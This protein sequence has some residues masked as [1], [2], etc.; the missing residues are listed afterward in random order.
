MFVK[1]R[2]FMKFRQL[3]VAAAAGVA[4]MAAGAASAAT[5]TWTADDLEQTVSGGSSS[6]SDVLTFTIATGEVG[7]LSG[8]FS[9][10]VS[11]TIKAL[12]LT[13]VDLLLGSTVLYSS[14]SV[15]SFSFTGLT[16][17]SYSLSLLYDKA[18]KKGGLITGY[19]TLTTTPSV[20]EPESVAM[21][22]AGLGVVGGLARR[23]RMK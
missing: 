4:F 3:M 19:A 11:G 10:Y 15:S 8:S 12:N 22:L 13:S 2:F 5:Q 7:A 1:R 14:S 6:L 9:S 21:A 20:P 17:G 23:R 18:S 16:A